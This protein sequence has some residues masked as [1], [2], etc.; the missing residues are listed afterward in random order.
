MARALFCLAAF[1]AADEAATFNIAFGGIAEPCPL[2]VLWLGNNTRDERCSG[3]WLVLGGVELGE[4]AFE[5]F[6]F[7]AGFGEFALG[8]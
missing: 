1:R 4:G 3:A 5:L 6:E 7:L 2:V 8:G